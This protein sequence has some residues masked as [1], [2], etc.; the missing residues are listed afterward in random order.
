MNLCELCQKA[1]AAR[2]GCCWACYSKLR[3]CDIPLPPARAPG[4]APMDAAARLRSLVERLAP[5]TR[6][7]LHEATRPTSDAAPSPS[8]GRV[9]RHG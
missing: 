9:V 3:A 5:R 8:S 4:P 2:R 1:P 7:L 6:L